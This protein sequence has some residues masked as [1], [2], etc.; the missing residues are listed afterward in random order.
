MSNINQPNDSAEKLAINIDKKLFQE[1]SNTIDKKYKSQVRALT[2]LVLSLIPVPLIIILSFASINPVSRKFAFYSIVIMLILATVGCILAYYSDKKEIQDIDDINTLYCYLDYLINPKLTKFKYATSMAWISKKLQK[3]K[4]NPLD[5][6]NS[7][8]TKLINIIYPIIKPFSNKNGHCEATYRKKAFVSLV[9]KIFKGH[10]IHEDVRD[11]KRKEKDTDIEIRLSD[12]RD[13]LWNNRSY[14]AFIGVILIHSLAI[15][16]KFGGE[17]AQD[18]SLTNLNSKEAFYDLATI[19]PT[20]FIAL[21]IYT[22][23]VKETKKEE[24]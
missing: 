10:D 9:D 22:G 8:F 6:Q 16:I 18:F 5:G 12:L 17:N 23:F 11:F 3:R 2:I 13:F 7:E 15:I 4:K 24:E 14:I 21:L 1:I 19:L 20:D